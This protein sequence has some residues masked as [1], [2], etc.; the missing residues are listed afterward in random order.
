MELMDGMQKL[1][2]ER[3]NSRDHGGLAQAGG[4]SSVGHC[5]V[6]MYRGTRRERYGD[7]RTATC[8]LCEIK[9][10]LRVFPMVTARLA[11][12]DEDGRSFL[13]DVMGLQ[14]RGMWWTLAGVMNVPESKCK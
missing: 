3:R 14:L 6:P 5:T 2:G 11:V 10:A 7:A 12:R 1:P 13:H 9:H 4:L 8:Q